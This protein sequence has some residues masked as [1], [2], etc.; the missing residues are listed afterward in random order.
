VACTEKSNKELPFGKLSD[1]TAF[2]FG[3][4]EDGIS[5]DLI[6]MCDEQLKIPMIGGVAS[7]N[8]SVSVGMVLYEMNR[9]RLIK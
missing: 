8:V 6:R 1:S 9:Q 7:L 3:S 2:I 4:E 5:N